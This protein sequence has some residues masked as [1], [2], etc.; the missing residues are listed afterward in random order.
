M[1]TPV[2]RNK[3]YKKKTHTGKTEQQMA[4][5]KQQRTEPMKYEQEAQ[6]KHNCGWLGRTFLNF[7]QFTLKA[8]SA[9][10]THR[11]LQDSSVLF[12]R[13]TVFFL[14]IS[15]ALFSGSGQ[16]DDDDLTPLFPRQTTGSC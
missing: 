10:M 9:Q 5:I 8:F 2:R 3:K 11:R 15:L 7:Q 16:G 6:G 4:A 1:K 12:L 14:L 13:P